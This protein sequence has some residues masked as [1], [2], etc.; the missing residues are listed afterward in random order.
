MGIVITINIGKGGVGKSTIAAQLA[1]VYAAQGKSVVVIDGDDT[2]TLMKFFSNRNEA[3]ESGSFPDLRYVK[4]EHHA[5]Q[6]DIRQVLKHLKAQYDVIL[7]DTMGGRSNLFLTSIQLSNVILIP[8]QTSRKS[9]DQLEPTLKLIADVD[10][11][12]RAVPTFEEYSSD[13]RVLLNMAIRGTK[14]FRDAL[15]LKKY[16]TQSINFTKTIIP[17]IQAL[18]SFEDDDSGLTLTDTRHPKRAVF[19]LLANELLQPSSIYLDG[20]EEV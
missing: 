7:I 19:E 12:I 5:P 16:L 10:E 1:G 4:C 13:V 15:E 18:D 17:N 9:F 14:A 2:A 8:V 3:I 6:T 20:N 11:N